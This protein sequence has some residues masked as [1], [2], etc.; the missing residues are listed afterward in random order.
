M[1]CA[2]SSR[3]LWTLAQ[4]ERCCK[5]ARCAAFTQVVPELLHVARTFNL[6]TMVHSQQG[7]VSLTLQH[8]ACLHAGWRCAACRAVCAGQGKPEGGWQPCHLKNAFGTTLTGE[9]VSLALRTAN[10]ITS[11][12]TGAEASMQCSYYDAAG[13][14]AGVTCTMANASACARPGELRAHARLCLRSARAHWR[15]PRVEHETLS[16]N[17]YLWRQS[18]AAFFRQ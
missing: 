4:V 8:M 10:S 3:G 18:C 1:V 17:S 6:V 12:Y 9:E 15:H 2:K 7:H 5:L 11:N 13:G 16:R 14:Q